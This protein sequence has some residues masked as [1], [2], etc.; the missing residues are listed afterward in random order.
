[1]IVAHTELRDSVRGLLKTL[2]PAPQ[3][4]AAWQAA[5]DAG[6]FMLTLPE[7][8][9]GLEQSL[10]AASALYQ[11]LGEAVAPIPSLASM[12]AVDAFC[13]CPTS[14][15]RDE[16]LEK[17]SGGEPVMVSLLDPSATGITVAADASL[18]GTLQAVAGAE[19]ARHVLLV[20]PQAELVLLLPLPCAGAELVARP[21]WDG[22]RKLCDLV[23]SK[24]KYDPAWVLARGDAVASVMAA[25]S[26][27][28]HI[29]LAADSIGG[30]HELLRQTIEHLKTRRQF[31]RPLA[32]FQALKHRCADLITTVRAAE[33][34]LVT[35]LQ[36][37]DAG[38]GDPVLLA[39]AAKSICSDAYRQVAEESVQLHG[40][41]GM[42]S[43]HPCHV[44]LKRALLNEHL[45][46]SNEACDLAVA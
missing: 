16:W 38:Q 33:A 37:I 23:L 32:M 18:N 26:V 15:L 45:G 14:A 34:V 40:G 39:L 36:D 9:G 31:D 11:E 13:A 30:A 28:L 27:H 43:E 20:L 29:A 24:V 25:M 21:T 41:M 42:T 12:L 35:Y 22:T 44:F 10:S 7:A 8:L 17:L 46:L 6:W 19:H 2:G 5:T 4:D 3:P 1:M